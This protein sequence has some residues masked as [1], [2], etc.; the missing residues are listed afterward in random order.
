MLIVFIHLSQQLSFSFP[1]S[2]PSIFQFLVF[3]QEQPQLP[4]LDLTDIVSIIFSISFLR[5]R[6]AAASPDDEREGEV[7]GRA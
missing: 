6:T 2:L 7:G 5:A 3:Q 4:Q 1:S